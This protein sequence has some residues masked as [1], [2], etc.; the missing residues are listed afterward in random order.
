MKF[1]LCILYNFKY[2]CQALYSYKLSFDFKSGSGSL[3]YLSN[4]EIALPE[5]KIWFWQK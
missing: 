1:L 3:S 4:K 2:K 5:D